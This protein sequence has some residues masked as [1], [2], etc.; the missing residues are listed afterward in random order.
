MN[1]EKYNKENRQ[2]GKIHFRNSH[3]SSVSSALNIRQVTSGK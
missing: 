1:A 2:S 3:N